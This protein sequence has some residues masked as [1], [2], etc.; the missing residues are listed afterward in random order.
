MVN[1]NHFISLGYDA[2]TYENVSFVVGAWGQ[3]QKPSFF[4]KLGFFPD[5]FCS[6][7]HPT[8]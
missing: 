3:K 5:G 8:S 6:T 7:P 2:F 4:K 1:L